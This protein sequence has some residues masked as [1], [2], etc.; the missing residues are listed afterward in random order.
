MAG[1]PVDKWEGCYPSQWKGLVVDGAMK[2][3]AKY[4]SRLIRRIYDHLVAE[5]W[6]K[7]GDSVLDPFGGV[8]LGAMD[9]MRH[10][11]QWVGIELEERFHVLAQGNIDLWQSKFGVLPKWGS[12]RILHGDSRHL[13]ELVQGAAQASISSPPY[14]QAR[15]G[16]ESGQENCG[17]GD[18]YGGTTG[19][20]G[21]MEA[22]DFD[23]AISSPPYA[24]SINS[25]DNGID[26][27]K[28]KKDYPGRV[29]HDERV[30]HVDAIHKGYHYG[31]TEGQLGAMKA[32]GFDAAVS[33]PPFRQ[34]TGGSSQK[35]LDPN[36]P[37][38]AAL[39][40]RHAAGNGSSKAYGESGGQL[41]N[42][43][44][45]DFQAAVSSPPYGDSD[46]NY[47]EGWARF[48]ENH[49]PLW[50]NDQQREAEYGES[51]G[52]LSAMSTAD[53]EAAV[54]SPPYGTKTDRKVAWGSTMDKDLQAEDEAR[55]YRADNSF[56]G[57][58][59]DD[60]AN[61]GNPTGADDSS[62]WLAARGIVDQVYASLAP[63]GHAVWVV[64]DYVKDGERVQ[65]SD[66]WRQLCEAAGFKTVHEHHAMLVHAKQSTMDGGVKVRESKS[67]FR[68]L[69][70]KKG[71]PRIDWEVIFCMEKAQ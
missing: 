1:H 38:D 47:K 5:G 30:A 16:Q 36:G 70:E 39:H 25:S 11:L 67:F 18:Q 13:V 10:G 60:P 3:P 61:L 4:S 46:Q 45:G 7:P 19:Q 55:G 35:N 56:R 21:A 24:D 17:R 66:Q 64:K 50:K 32:E 53:F 9:A 37:I 44:E 2:H 40:A 29:Q 65:F 52:Q 31:E 68:R 34:A 6:V 15:I 54:S 49:A 12:A 33:S 27:T 28:V 62:F 22:G 71:S 43:E 23:A 51:A 42:M 58:Y 69:A 57:T 59:S 20:L 14:A 41:A 26:W 48:H 63:G 8:G